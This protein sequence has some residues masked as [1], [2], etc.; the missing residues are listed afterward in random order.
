[1]KFIQTF[2]VFF[3][4]EKS[5]KWSV[6]TLIFTV[7][8]ASFTYKSNESPFQVEVD[9][10]VYGGSSAGLIAAYTAKKLGKSV[11]VIEPGNYLGGLTAGGLG[12]TDIGNKYAITGLAK[13]FYRRLGQH[14]GKFEQWVFEPHVADKV[15]ADMIKE[16]KLDI[17]KNH[18]LIGVKKQDGYIT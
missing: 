9:V 11:I 7:A 12:A 14:Y 6:I 16:A 3:R 10:C 5:L 17:V 4:R 15:Y 2:L 1:M 13:D 18:R 8:L